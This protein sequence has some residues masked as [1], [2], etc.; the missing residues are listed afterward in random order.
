LVSA[1]DADGDAITQYRLRRKSDAVTNDAGGSAY[2]SEF[3]ANAINFDSAGIVARYLFDAVEH[4]QVK[5]YDGAAWSDWIDFDVTTLQTEL[6]DGAGI[7]NRNAPVHLGA[8]S[9]SLHYSDWIGGEDNDFV[10]LQVESA[11]TLSLALSGTS[12][13]ARVWLADEA[14]GNARVI[15]TIGG[16]PNVEARAVLDIPASGGALTYSLGVGSYYVGLSRVNLSTNYDLAI[17]FSPA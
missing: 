6:A 2:D 13:N 12:E 3:T 11:G 8:T 5:A 1:T 10:Y 4:W 15:T 17:A 9:M 14:S 7:E 16:S